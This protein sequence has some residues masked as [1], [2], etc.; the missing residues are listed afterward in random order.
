MITT[1]RVMKSIKPLVER[2]TDILNNCTHE[3]LVGR[4]VLLNARIQGDDMEAMIELAI[5]SYIATMEEEQ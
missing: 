3:E 5:M 4:T 1:K 2:A